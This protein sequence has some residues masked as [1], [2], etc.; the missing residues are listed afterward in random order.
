MPG[1]RARSR[2]PSGLRRPPR[3]A[4]GREPWLRASEE[5]KCDR[6]I[7]AH[8]EHQRDRDPRAPRTSRSQPRGTHHR[9]HP[10]ACAS[11]VPKIA[12]WLPPGGAQPPYPRPRGRQQPESR[13]HEIAGCR[14]PTA[15]PRAR[16]DAGAC[17][18]M[19]GIVGKGLGSSRD[20]KSSRATVSQA[21]H[22]SNATARAC[23][24]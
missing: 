8:F 17:H 2:S 24:R 10:S 1:E 15:F 4:V 9:A 20:T 6:V 12:A 23:P 19:W 5:A 3:V 21:A 11:R 22:D 18:M 7:L 16:I 13:M 14:A